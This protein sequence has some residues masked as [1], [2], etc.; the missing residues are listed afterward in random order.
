MAAEPRYTIRRAVAPP[1]RSA[2]NV[3]S[4]VFFTGSTMADGVAD[5]VRPS[6]PS[7]P[8]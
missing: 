3:V 7:L 2:T 1:D 5:T 4:P 8:G 6:T